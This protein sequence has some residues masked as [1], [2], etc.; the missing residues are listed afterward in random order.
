MIDI[1]KLLS[2]EM[3]RYTSEYCY[4]DFL[5][6]SIAFSS[7]RHADRKLRAIGY[8]D[9]SLVELNGGG[10]CTQLSHHFARRVLDPL[11]LSWNWIVSS[12]AEYDN[13]AKAD[14]IPFRSTA[15]RVAAP[16]GSGSD[17]LYLGIPLGH[18]R[19]IPI[20]DGSKDTFWGKNY[21][22]QTVNSNRFRLWTKARSINRY[23][24]YY[25]PDKIDFESAWINLIYVKESYSI[26]A[27]HSGSRHYIGY[28]LATNRVYYTLRTAHL[29]S[30]PLDRFLSEFEKHLEQF[31]HQFRSRHLHATLL[32]IAENHNNLRAALVDS[33][34]LR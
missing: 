8:L 23:R 24:E 29:R 17:Y 9:L 7:A 31:D 26:T 21:L 18:Q 6:L 20:R 15:I 13:S 3:A 28:N 22:V 5:Y 25:L 4:D 1:I 19:P 2:E 33:T 11:S 34:R 12:D 27:Y 32:S 16:E 30:K 10:D 14:L